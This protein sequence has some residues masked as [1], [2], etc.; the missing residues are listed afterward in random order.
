MDINGLDYNTTREKLILSE[1]GR[2]VQTMIDYCKTI[3]NRLVR[4]QCAATIVDVMRAI[5]QQKHTP[6]L[7]EKLWNHLAVMGNFELD[8]E[9]PYEVTLKDDFG[10]R[11]DPLRYPMQNIRSRHY[12][13]LLEAM[14]EEL[15]HME[16]GARKDELSRLAA[17]QMKRMQFIWNRGSADGETIISELARFTDGAV[18]LDPSKFV[19][20]KVT[21]GEVKEKGNKKKKK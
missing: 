7:D 2:E 14:F 20:D 5:S 4:Q 21:V 13:H 10:K 19:F 3:S 16:E 9:Y 17:N 6:G 1:Y 18:Q 11:P 12:G 8:I 15:K